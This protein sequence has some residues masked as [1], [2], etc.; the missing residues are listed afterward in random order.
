MLWPLYVTLLSIWAASYI[1]ISLEMFN[2]RQSELQ[3]QSTRR[4]FCM[5]VCVCVCVK[6]NFLTTTLLSFN[7]R[8]L[9][10]E[11]YI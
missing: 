4:H 5:R 8:G 11:I 7:N 9:K 3:L 2:S 6:E 10:K 1:L